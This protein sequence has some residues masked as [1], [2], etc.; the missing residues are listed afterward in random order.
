LGGRAQHL[1]EIYQHDLHD[2]APESAELKHIE[3]QVVAE[4]ARKVEP[5]N[6]AEQGSYG[7]GDWTRRRHGI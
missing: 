3:R 5:K 6:T 7:T 1:T 4:L 2:K